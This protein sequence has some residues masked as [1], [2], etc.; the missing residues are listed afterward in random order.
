MARWIALVLG[1]MVVGLLLA[2]MPWRADAAQDD[3]IV[4][5]EHQIG[6]LDAR[7][8]ALERERDLIC[9]SGEIDGELRVIESA[10]VL[11][12]TLL[13]HPDTMPDSSNPLINRGV[14]S[15]TFRDCT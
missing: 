4:V 12:A 6:L 15:A 5:L 1:V 10:G 14:G 13:W 3:R 7:I 8:A 11:Q 9:A 2:G